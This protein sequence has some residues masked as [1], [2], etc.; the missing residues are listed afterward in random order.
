MTDTAATP[1]ETAVLQE[2]CKQL[3]SQD[4]KAFEEQIK[5]ISVL[6]RKNTGAGFFTY[7]ATKGKTVPQLKDDTKGC[8]VT[9]KIN[10]LENALGFILWLKDG[11]V[12]HLEGYTMALESTVGM[13]LAALEFELTS[14]P[15]IS[16]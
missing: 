4:R 3:R 12:D 5:G 1:L 11:Y 15:A 6:S 9:A 14:P 16:N 8:Y 10:G 2:I 7:F 13:D